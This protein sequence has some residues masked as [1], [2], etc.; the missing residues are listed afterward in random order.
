MDAQRNLLAMITR[1]PMH[2]Q[3]KWQDHVFDLK[4]RENRRPTLKDVVKFVD[5]AA[6]VVSDP[7]YGSASIRSKRAEKLTTRA[8]YVVT[9]DVHCPICDEGEHSVSQCRKFIDMN[10]NERLDTA[11]RKQICFMCLNPGH[12][13]RECTN[14]VKCQ[15][16]ECGQRHATMLHEADWEG[17][18]RTSREKREAKASSS[19]ETEG[20]HGHHVASSHHVMGSKV[21]LPFLLV[22]ITSPETGISVKTYALLDSGSSVS[23]CQDKLLQVLKARGRTEKMSLMTLE[24]KNHEATARVVSLKVSSL[25]GN[26]ELAI[27]QVFARPNL[28]LNS[29]NLVTE[30]EVQRWPHLK[31]LPLHHAEMDDV[32]LLIGQDYPEAL[33]PLTTIPGGKGEP[34]AVMTRLGWSVSGPVSHSTVKVPPTS[35]YVSNGD[36]LHE[37]V[38]H[39]WKIESSG[40]YEREKGMSVEDRRVLELWDSNVSFSDGHYSLPIPFKN[41]ALTLPDNRQMAE[42][43][44]S[45]LK[46]K[47][48]KNHDLHRKYMDGMNDLLEKGY[49]VPVAKE[50]VYKNDGKMWYLPHH[51]VINSNKEKIRIVFDCAA[52]Y[53]GISLNSKVRQGPDLTNKLVGVLTHFCLHPV[54]IMADIQAMFHQVRVTLENQDASEIAYGVVSYLRVIATDGSVNCTIVMAKSRLAPIK[55]LTV[56]RLELQAAT[57]AARQNALLRK[58]L[59]LDL[60]SS[61]F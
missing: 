56:P 2:L 47:L 59:N 36:L 7:V 33:M 16:K 9:A 60:G 45:S 38:E 5:R 35:H 17:L 10:P 1:L 4:S 42:R 26:E 51:P 58:E 41:P 52:E 48:L 27:P 46:R 30:A 19:P 54:A 31:D 32:T 39:F 50:D 3:S 49:A 40:I 6:P 28:H 34:Y 53:N 13:T 24:R 55:K 8:A 20:Y 37:K 61:T 22:K 15:A 23:L 21:A 57:L 44:L 29:S 25:Y 12:I 43:R 18:R 11:L 14:P